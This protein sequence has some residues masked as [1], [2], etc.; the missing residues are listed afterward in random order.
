VSGDAASGT[1]AGGRDAAASVADAAAGG[2]TPDLPGWKLVWAEEF[3]VDGPPD[4]ASWGFERGFV[5]N[6]ELQWYQPQNAAVA[7]GI[8]TIEGRKEQVVNPNYLAGSTD[9]RRNRAQSQ[10]TS[11]SITTSGKHAFSYGRFTMRARIDTRQG[12]WPAFW[13]LGVGV[14][15]PQ[16]GEVDIMEFYASTV[17]AN[18]C[19]PAGATCGWSSVRQSLA[20]LGA[21][22]SAQFHVWTMDWDAQKIDL[23]LDDVLVNHFA[24]A[25]AVP[26]GQVNPYI[27][28]SMFLLVNLALGANGGDPAATVFPIKYEVDWIRVYQPAAA[29]PGPAVATSV[30]AR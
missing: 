3:D 9:W 10:Y 2:G 18:V 13:A 6:Q 17:L 8:L 25:D 1:A 20:K 24:V 19:K 16:S 22:W 29:L 4:P 23:F 21:A 27:G 14:P 15:W 28:K 5:R 26:A 7:G 12:S 11:S 30:G